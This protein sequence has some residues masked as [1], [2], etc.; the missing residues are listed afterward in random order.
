MRRLALYVFPTLGQRPIAEIEAP[1]LLSAL[2]VIEARGKHTTAH[3]ARQYVGMVFRYGIATGCC[4]RNSFKNMNTIGR[5]NGS[6]YDAAFHFNGIKRLIY[7]KCER[8][9]C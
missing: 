7:N 9:Y 2:R 1:E 5:I 4:K 8:D 3:L 6:T